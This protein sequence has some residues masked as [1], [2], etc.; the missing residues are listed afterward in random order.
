MVNKRPDSK[1]FIFPTAHLFEILSGEFCFPLEVL[2]TDYMQG[3][4]SLIRSHTG[5]RQVPDT[6][7]ELGQ[8]ALGICGLMFRCVVWLLLSG[9]GCYIT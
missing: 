2:V 5:V 7:A 1:I 3:F 4:Q 9:V 6:P 8:S